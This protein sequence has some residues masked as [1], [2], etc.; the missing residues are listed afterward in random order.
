MKKIF[1]K[2]PVVEL[3][4]DEMT[5]II[6]Q[7]I[8]EELSAVLKEN[9]ASVSGGFDLVPAGGKHMDSLAYYINGESGRI[10]GRQ[11]LLIAIDSFI[12][13]KDGSGFQHLEPSRR[14]SLEDV[15]Q[16]AANQWSTY[17]NREHGLEITPEQFKEAL[18]SGAITTKKNRPPQN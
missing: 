5:K 14:P 8:K 2:N 13:I 12:S 15:A 9:E 4:G 11:A 6:W 10:V 1:V 18:L 3:D 7:L 17:L 16:N